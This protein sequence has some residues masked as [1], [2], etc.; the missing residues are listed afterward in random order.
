MHI[1]QLFIIFKNNKHFRISEEG[2]EI[3]Q[4]CN[5]I[6]RF[7]P[8]LHSHLIIIDENKLNLKNIEMILQYT[9]NMMS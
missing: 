5:N 7:K 6:K 2:K 9:L 4:I 1:V 8:T 3:C